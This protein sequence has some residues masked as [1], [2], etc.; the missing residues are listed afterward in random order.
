MRKTDRQ[1][2]G[3]FNVLVQFD[4]G[5]AGH[6]GFHECSGLSSETTAASGPSKAAGKSRV[7]KISGMNKS[8]DVTLKRGLVSA[9][10]LNAWLDDVRKGKKA[11]RDLTLVLQ[12]EDPKKPP[13]KWKLVRARIIKHTSGPLNAKGTDV[14]MEELVLSYDRIE[15]V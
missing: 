1:P 10:V 8:T 11:S 15:P 6:A 13:R 9:P 5:G 2:Y 7:S 4:S 3:Q 14:A 12:N